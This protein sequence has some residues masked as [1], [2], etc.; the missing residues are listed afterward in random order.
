MKNISSN[1]SC[2]IKA[3][4]SHLEKELDEEVKLKKNVELQVFLNELFGTVH[5]TVGDYWNAEVDD[6]GRM[7]GKS[8]FA[9]V[10]IEEDRMA[11]NLKFGLGIFMEEIFGQDVSP[12]ARR[13]MEFL[14]RDRR[15]ERV[16]IDQTDDSWE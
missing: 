6:E 14:M 7:W 1:I 8:N 3:I 13:H 12:E 9:Y 11:D 4:K 10:R 2:Y 5:H 16:L 15:R